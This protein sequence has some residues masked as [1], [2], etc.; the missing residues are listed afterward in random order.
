MPGSISASC[1]FTPNVVF[2]SANPARHTHVSASHWSCWPSASDGPRP[3]ADILLPIVQWSW[4]GF[5]WKD[6]KTES[7]YFTQGQIQFP[8]L[9][10]K[11]WEALLSSLS[12]WWLED[13]RV[14]LVTTQRRALLKLCQWQSLGPWF[15][16]LGCINMS[17]NICVWWGAGLSP[18]IHELT[19]F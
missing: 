11:Q 2:E 17:L 10:R 7:F 12:W 13:W 6:K 9:I 19:E 4:A 16:P 5:H 18:T 1:A 3:K 15:F 14:L 8:N